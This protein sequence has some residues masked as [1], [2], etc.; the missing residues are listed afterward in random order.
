M[1][2][3]SRLRL[4][5]DIH[6]VIRLELFIVAAISTILITRI[7]LIVMNYPQIGGDGLHIAHML[8]GGLLML[9]SHVLLLGF[10]G[11]RVKELS[12]FVG[13]V[14]FGLFIDEV[15]KFVTA[16]NDY[17][18]QPSFAIMY[19]VF[20][21]LVLWVHWFSERPVYDSATQLANATVIGAG[22]QL[23]GLDDIAR[24]EAVRLVDSAEREGADQRSVD[25][26]RE[27]I[28]AS[29]AARHGAGRY[30][31]VRARLLGWLRAIVRHRAAYALLVAFL[32]LQLIDSVAGIAGTRLDEMTV[33]RGIQL[34][35]ALLT[36]AIIVA[37]LIYWRRGLER[38]LLFLRYA[39]LLNIMV[40]QVFNFADRE[41]SAFPGVLVNL[42]ALAVL[43]YR[44]RLAESSPDGIPKATGPMDD[45]PRAIAQSS[46]QE[47][48]PARTA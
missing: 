31:A 17:F 29:P 12:A 35:W 5:Q 9:V 48:G 11:P 18:F 38:G 15:G 36:T 41:L 6:A 26:V 42:G 19:V 14:G 23:R 28:A 43:N 27:L 25:A 46:E 37:G 40:G 20:V 2:F 39:V 8:W 45:E 16:D 30:A 22:G 3:R 24:A 47:G 1:S 34:G 13:G 21:L 10:L 44:V 4:G 32:V 7:Y 33:A